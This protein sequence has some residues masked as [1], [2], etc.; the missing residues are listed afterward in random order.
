MFENGKLCSVYNLGF[1]NANVSA[2]SG[3]YTGILFGYCDSCNVSGIRIYSSI[4]KGSTNVG[5]IFGGSTNSSIKNSTINF[6]NLVGGKKFI[7][8]FFPIKKNFFFKDNVGSV[9]GESHD[10]LVDN[11]ASINNTIT[12]RIDGG[13]ILGISYSSVLI[14]NSISRNNVFLDTKY[15]SNYYT[16]G[17]VGT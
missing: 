1:I 13:G 17:F 6:S 3:T 12:A 5:G 9:S 15:T 10:F 16:A 7:I 4:I 14:N 2:N 8:L 11:C